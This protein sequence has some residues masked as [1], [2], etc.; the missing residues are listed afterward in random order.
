MNFPSRSAS[1]SVVP[2]AVRRPSVSSRLSSA[3]SIAERG[4]AQDGQ[5]ITAQHQIEEEIAKIKRYEVYISLV[6]VSH[7][8]TSD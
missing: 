3:V 2:Q 4:E 8:M 5:G 7:A 6:A 1:L